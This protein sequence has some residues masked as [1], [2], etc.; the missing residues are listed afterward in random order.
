[1][2]NTTPEDL[3]EQPE[4]VS[5][6]DDLDGDELHRPEYIGEEI[7]PDEDPNYG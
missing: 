5:A 4:E 1:M 2:T 6:L 3:P 7:L